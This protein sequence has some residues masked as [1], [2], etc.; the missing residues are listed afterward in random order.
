MWLHRVLVVAGGLLSC[1]AR[2][3]LFHGMWD[4]PGPGI[5]PMSPALA[6]NLYPLCHQGSPAQCFLI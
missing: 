1:S 4:L 2:A 5:E 3:Q 6:G